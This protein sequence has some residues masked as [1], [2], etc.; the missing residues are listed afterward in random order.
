[1]HTENNYIGQTTPGVLPNITGS[2]KG[3]I[4]Q[5]ADGAFYTAD[6]GTDGYG[7][8]VHSEPRVYFDASR[9]NSIYG[10]GW[11]S[12]ERVI[13]NGVGVAYIIKY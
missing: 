12:A 10:N 2:F 8:Q 1:M 9:S 3:S 7:S 11:F 5:N 4:G 13:P 6:G